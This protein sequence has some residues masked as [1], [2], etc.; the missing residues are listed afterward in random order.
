MRPCTIYGDWGTSRLRLWLVRDGA[1]AEFREGPG[2]GQVG[3]TPEETLRTAIAPWIA[4]HAP[5]AIRLCGMAGA[6]NGLHEVAYADCPTDAAAWRGAAGELILE[7]VPLRI[8]AGVA[9]RD[10]AGRADVMRGEE[11]QIFGAMRLQ[12]GFGRGRHV[13]V[14]PGTHSKWVTIEEGRIT[15]FRTFL[16]GELFA[17]VRGSSLLAAARENDSRSGNDGFCEGLARAAEAGILLGSLFEARA[18]QLRDDRSARWAEDFVSGVLLGAE[19]AEIARLGQLPRKVAVIGGADLA[20]RYSRALALSHVASI[21]LD[22]DDCSLAGL[23]LLDA[24]D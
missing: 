22:G 6:R 21:A 19:L 11:T 12:P 23:E 15:A 16:T 17:L 13:I 5:S 18:A 1:V 4:G 20:E 9:W 8:G 10:A 2:I 14:L 24:D 7:G 3:C